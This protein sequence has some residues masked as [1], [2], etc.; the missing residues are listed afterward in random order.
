MKQLHIVTYRNKAKQRR[1]V[2][3]LKEHVKETESKAS[4]I[5]REINGISSKQN[6]G[7]EEI[8]V[9]IKLFET[10]LIP[11]IFY[12]FEVW[13]KILKSEMQA[14]EKIQNQSLKKILQ[15][16]VTTRQ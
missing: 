6:V 8:R 11:A 15:L 1:Q 4:R 2:G 3:N 9:K 5:L 14:I 10:C 7:Q 13:G 12:G 16:P